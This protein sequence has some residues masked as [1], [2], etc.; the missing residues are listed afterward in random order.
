MAKFFQSIGALFAT[1]WL[2]FS[3]LVALP[4]KDYPVKFDRLDFTAEIAEGLM[5]FDSLNG[6][7]TKDE[8][9]RLKAHAKGL[10]NPVNNFTP[11]RN[12]YVYGTL[13][14]AFE[15]LLRLYE[16]TRDQEILDILVNWTD[17][18]IHSRNDMPG[19]EQR[20]IWN[21]TIAP[22]WPNEADIYKV[23]D[24]EQGEIIGKLYQVALFIYQ[25]DLD[26]TYIKKANAF[27]A[28]AEESLKEYLIPT[29][30]HE[31]TNTIRYPMDPRF[32]DDRNPGNMNS[33]DMGRV[34]MTNR[35]FMVAYAFQYAAEVYDYL[36]DEEFSAFCADVTQKSLDSF[37]NSL[38]VNK[39]Y[40]VARFFRKSKRISFAEWNY[41]PVKDSWVEDYGHGAFDMLAYYRILNSG[42]YTSAGKSVELVCNMI[43][44]RL[45]RG[46]GTFASDVRG[47]KILA[48]PPTTQIRQNYLLMAVHDPA[49]MKLIT[50]PYVMSA[51]RNVSDY[52]TVLYLKAALYGIE[53]L[54]GA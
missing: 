28:R 40:A 35:Q 29:F 19:G 39:A 1:V 16:V 50:K 51:L 20:V 47:R 6:M 15:A 3:N 37:E 24:S 30:I 12:S 25:S 49:I 9:A 42:R 22:V 2:M 5:V 44:H 11:G 52:G 53:D 32:Y 4:N 10:A 14:N 27:V 26:Q 41:W 46:N 38:I 23:P 36:G 18:I 54:E 8:L 34:M 7:L 21:D 31:E 43:V 17:H 13:G 48:D 45:H 33:S